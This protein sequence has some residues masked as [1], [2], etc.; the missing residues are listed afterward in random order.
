MNVFFCPRRQRG[1]FLFVRSPSFKRGKIIPE[2]GEKKRKGE[3][4]LNE[5]GSSRFVS[6]ENILSS[7]GV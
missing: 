2:V 6:G 7:I 1:D 5:R 4:D 3:E